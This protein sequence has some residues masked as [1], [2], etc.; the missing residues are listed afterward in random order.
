MTKKNKGKKKRF[1]FF[2]ARQ[3]LFLTPTYLHS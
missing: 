3:G 2:W 1:L